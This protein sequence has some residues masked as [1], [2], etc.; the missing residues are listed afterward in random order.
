MMVA[1][2]LELAGACMYVPVDHTCKPRVRGLQ[3]INTW[4]CLCTVLTVLTVPP[5]PTVPLLTASK[6]TVLHMTPL[7]SIV[8]G[9]HSSEYLGM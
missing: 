1:D 8:E 2:W 3:A 5:V 7:L 6:Y 4:C 9:H